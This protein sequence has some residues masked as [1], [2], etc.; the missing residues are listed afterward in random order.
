VSNRGQSET[1]SRND[2][3]EEAAGQWLER[4][5]LGSLTDEETGEFEAWKSQ[6]LAHRVA[7]V[8]LE[9]TWQRTERLA[10]LHR[11]MLE[12]PPVGGNPGGRLSPKYATALGAVLLVGAGVFFGSQHA[13]DLAYSTDVGN[14]E[15]ISLA[16]GSHIEL[17]TNSALRVRLGRGRREVYLDKGEA[18][19]DVS[20]D[21]KR[22]FTVVA[23]G[24]RVT[25]IGTKFSVREDANKVEV[26]LVEG[27]ARLDLSATEQSSRSEMLL[28]G[29]VAIATADQI[30]MQKLSGQSIANQLGW[31]RG[32]IVFDSTPLGKAVAEVNRYNRTKLVVT[33][34][35]I[36]RLTI[37]GTFPADNFQ[38]VVDAAR[39][40]YGLHTKRH[41]DSIEIL[42]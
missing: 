12:K 36:S 25:D 13:G 24:H 35:S 27:K 32:V 40:V 11:P 4:L 29:D 31:R 16:D 26:A 5:A 2:E 38:I 7:Y 41:E 18:Y 39:D 21:A 3:I 34:P 15:I 23:L 17:N 22:P 42:R 30:S 33:D 19:F 9:A 20:H 10:A 37:S 14:R 28:P 6:S 8:R 1:T